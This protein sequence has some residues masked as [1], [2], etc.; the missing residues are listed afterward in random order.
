MRIAIMNCM[1]TDNGCISAGCF[2]ALKEK[3]GAFADYPQAPDLAAFF[4]CG[5][6]EADR[7][8]DPDFLKKMDRLKKEGVERIHIGNC[9]RGCDNAQS[10][11][12][13]LKEHGFDLRL[14]TH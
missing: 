9:A 12:Q 3:S 14:G 7:R 11:Q 5:G 6:C 4:H 8:A 2:K 10:I 1:K 13:T